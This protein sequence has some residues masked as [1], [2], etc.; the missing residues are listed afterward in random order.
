MTTSIEENLS[1]PPLP[2]SPLSGGAVGLSTRRRPSGSFHSDDPC[3]PDV[4]RMSSSRRRALEDFLIVCGLAAVQATN[5]IYIVLL[6]PILSL[7]VKPSFLIISGSLAT[8]VFILPFA[9]AYEQ[10]RWPSRLTSTLVAQF[11]LIALGGVTTFQALMMLGI[12]KTSPAIASAMPNLAP[13]I[14]FITAASLGFEKVDMKCL[15]SRAKILGTLICLSGAMVMGFLQSPSAP[16]VHASERP[17]PPL[18]KGLYENKYDK[19]SHENRYGD[20]IIGFMCLLAAVFV[21]SCTTIL[22]AA[23][24]VHFPAPFT[25]CVIT[26]LIGAI[27]TAI[28][29]IITEGKLEMGPSTIS[30]TSVMAIV[31][32]G[33]IVGS[34]CISFQTWAV[35][36]KGPVMVSMFSP[37]STVCSAILSAIILGQVIKLESL[38]GMLAMFFGLYM[39][40]WAKNKEGL[41]LSAMASETS[42]MRS[43]VGDLERTLLS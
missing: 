33:A 37:I 7:G 21:V 17:P 4:A 11:L 13:G 19:D 30:F 38:V 22:Q 34:I 23:T 3:I 1:Y 40:L 9:I 27:I 24:M 6:T 12:K 5:A 10:K 18:D 14:I 25:L 43:S 36:K 29:Q 39:V 28:V 35:K 42:T 15:Y 32:L 2:S 26:S 8:S 20:W 41:I 31:L 16:S